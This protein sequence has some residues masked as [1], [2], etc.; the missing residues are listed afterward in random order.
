MKG[1]KNVNIEQIATDVYLELQTVSREDVLRI[2]NHQFKYTE[3]IINEG[4]GEIV[5]I[6][7]LGKFKVNARFRDSLIKG[8]DGISNTRG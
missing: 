4:E 1:L 6:D 8:K 3:R 7:F 5:K 2:F